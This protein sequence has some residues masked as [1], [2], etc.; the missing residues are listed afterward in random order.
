MSLRESEAPPTPA[1]TSDTNTNVKEEPVKTDKRASN[2]SVER[3]GSFRRAQYESDSE[4][5]DK[6]FDGQSQDSE[7]ERSTSAD[8]EPEDDPNTKPEKVVGPHLEII[9]RDFSSWPKGVA[10]EFMF[11]T[12]ANVCRTSSKAKVAKWAHLSDGYLDL[13]VIRK[14]SRSA[15]LKILMGAY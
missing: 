15:M 13:V 2:D 10:G 12:A 7:E 11:F 14:T 9:P 3:S 1:N 4:E 5:E 6:Q 8:S